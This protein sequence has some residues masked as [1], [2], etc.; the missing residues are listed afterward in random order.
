MGPTW[1]P[2]GS[3]RPQMG[4]MLAPWTFLLWYFSKVLISDPCIFRVFAGERGIRVPGDL[5]G[6]G[7]YEDYRVW[8]PPSSWCLS[9]KRME[10]A[11]FYNCSHRVSISFIILTPYCGCDVQ[12][13]P[14]P[15][16]KISLLET[17]PSHVGLLNGPLNGTSKT[18]ESF[19]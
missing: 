2:P 15:R 19:V 6:G 18:M 13:Q 14:V 4:P 11:R 16:N 7:V 9:Q 10:H 5:H 3:C 12:E 1:G 17:A 8:V